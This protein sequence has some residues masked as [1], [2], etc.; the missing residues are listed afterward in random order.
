MTVRS[1]TSAI[2]GGTN[3]LTIPI[4][5]G[6]FSFDYGGSLIVP[7]NQSLSIVV[8]AALSIAG[9]LSSFANIEW[10]EN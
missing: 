2:T 6:M 9:V 5:A 10:W 4:N 1:S 8:N 7:P 3:F